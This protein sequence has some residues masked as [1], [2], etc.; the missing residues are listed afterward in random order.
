[1]TQAP[2]TR[3]LCR[4]DRFTSLYHSMWE[5]TNHV[6]DCDSINVQINKCL[7]STSRQRGWQNLDPCHIIK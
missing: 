7:D 3:L 5:Y 4:E 2:K 6:I 1:M